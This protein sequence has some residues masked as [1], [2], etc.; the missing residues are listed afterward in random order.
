MFYC[1][2]CSQLKWNM[3][4]IFTRISHLQPSQLRLKRDPLCPTTP[5]PNPRS[6]C[7]AISSEVRGRWWVRE[8]RVGVSAAGGCS[9]GMGSPN[10]PGPTPHP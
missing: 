3:K 4:A 5:T 9:Q 10:G 7:R 8:G 1:F 6:I 2:K